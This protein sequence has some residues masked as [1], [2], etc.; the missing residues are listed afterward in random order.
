[1]TIHVV[2]VTIV[3]GSHLNETALCNVVEGIERDNVPSTNRTA[4]NTS[5]KGLQ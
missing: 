5:E 3:T 1:M 2:A 4:G